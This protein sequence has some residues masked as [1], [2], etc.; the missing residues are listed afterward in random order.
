MNID[1]MKDAG[2]LQDAKRNWERLLENPA[3]VQLIA[4]L[5]AQTDSLQQEILF[6]PVVASS[7]LYRL[8]RM[9]GQ[10]EGRLSITSTAQ[11]MFEGVQTDLNEALNKD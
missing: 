3:W 4:A 10:L 9:K 2:N 7:D 5:Q 1:D 11:A 8:E 6:G